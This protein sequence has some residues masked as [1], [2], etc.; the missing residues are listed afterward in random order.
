MNNLSDEA[1]WGCTDGMTRLQ[2]WQEAKRR[3]EATLEFHRNQYDKD[4]LGLQM[5]ILKLKERERKAFDW[6]AGW[7]GVGTLDEAF[8]AYQAA[9]EKAQ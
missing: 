4:L 9:Q 7:N 6:A 8:R 3:A 5:E 1:F 2:T